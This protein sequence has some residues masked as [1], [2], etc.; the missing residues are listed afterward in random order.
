MHFTQAKGILSS[1]NGINPYRGC[2]HGCIY[3]DSRSECYHTPK[4]FEDVEA[5]QNAPELLERALSSRRKKCMIGFGAMSDPY[6]P[7]EKELR[8]TRGCL[9]AILRHGFGAAVLTKSDL[10]LRD[11][12]LLREINRKS[13]CVVQMTLTAA[14]DN[15]CRLIE[16]NVCP[17]SRRVQV[18]RAFRE[19]GIETAVWLSPF[20]PFI[21]D[22]QENLDALMEL[23]I[24][25]RVSAV[26][27][28]GIGVTMRRGNREYF[29]AMLDRRFPGL[30]KK[31]EAEFGMRY[32]CASQNSGFLMERLAARCRE[33]GIIFGIDDPFRFLREFPQKEIQGELPF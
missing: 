21:T 20:L 24:G 1:S 10:I 6:L 5:K 32:E 7:L 25:A 3:C 27:C 14:D 11:R 4:P 12:E 18:L 17:T 16:P 28:F 15:L 26:V 31:Y 30:R 13:R 23:C 19:D 33:N 22:T 29:Y 8:L 2:T 9:E